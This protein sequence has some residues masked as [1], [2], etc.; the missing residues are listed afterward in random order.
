MRTLAIDFGARRV[1]LALSDEGGKFASPYEVLT[2]AT[3]EQARAEILA[4]IRKEGVGRIVVGLPLNMDDS[5]GPQARSTIAWAKTVGDE[6]ELPIIFVDERLSSFAA[7]QGLIARK[8][9]G[10]RITRG[11]KKQRLDALAASGFL[12][13]YLDGK[14]QP[15]PV[16]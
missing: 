2:V 13:E 7:E 5:F 9:G 15:I 3:P 12:Q 14:L 1:G 8:R 11:Q 10:E 4:V 16:D 6:A